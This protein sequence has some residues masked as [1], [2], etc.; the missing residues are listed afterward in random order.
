MPASVT[1]LG[2]AMLAQMDDDELAAQLATIDVLPRPTKRAHRT[3]RELRADLVVIRERGYAIDDEQNTIGVTCFAVAVP[4]PAQHIAVSTTLLTQ[5]VRPDL[6]TR[7]VADLT[8]L[9]HQLGTFAN[10]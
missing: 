7:L 8:V 5:R 10:R 4:A 1:A 3:V 9:A 2:K 6:R